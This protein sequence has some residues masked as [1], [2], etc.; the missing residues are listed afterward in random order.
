M[1]QQWI[2]QQF[3]RQIELWA[4]IQTCFG[5][6]YLENLAIQFYYKAQCGDYH[7]VSKLSRNETHFLYLLGYQQDYWQ[8]FYIWAVDII[9]DHDVQLG[10]YIYQIQFLLAN[11]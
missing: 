11:I 3:L 6:S 2:G 1:H 7:I 10:E 9:S 5:Q 8:H 4:N